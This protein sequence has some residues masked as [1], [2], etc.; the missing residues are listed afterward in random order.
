MFVWNW[1]VYEYSELFKLPSTCAKFNKCMYVCLT[2]SRKLK[3]YRI[4]MIHFNLNA[5]NFNIS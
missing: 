3:S 5:V 4:E 1:I 2:T